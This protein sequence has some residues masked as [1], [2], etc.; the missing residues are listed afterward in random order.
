MRALSDALSTGHRAMA[1]PTLQLHFGC[2]RATP[3]VS[4]SHNLPS[5]RMQN[6][7]FKIGQKSYFLPIKTQK[8][9]L[10]LEWYY[11]SLYC[12]SNA[13]ICHPGGCIFFGSKLDKKSYFLPIKTQKLI[14]T[15]EWYFRSLYCRSNA[16]IFKKNGQFE[17]DIIFCHLKAAVLKR[18]GSLFSVYFV[19]PLHNL[20]QLFE[21]HLH[22]FLLRMMPSKV[23]PVL[24]GPVLLLLYNSVTRR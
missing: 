23:L 5:G 4:H 10:T 13:M 24:Q 14:L 19:T 8:L 18:L 17:G 15:L 9:I 12:R 2:G 3:R 11:R 16:M 7:L 21:L 22:R 1:N 20:Y 6:F